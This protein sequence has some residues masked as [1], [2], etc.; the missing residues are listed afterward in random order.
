MMRV[1]FIQVMVL[2]ERFDSFHFVQGL[3]LKINFSFSKS[4]SCSVVKRGR[5]LSEIAITSYIFYIHIFKIFLIYSFGNL[6]C[7][8]HGLPFNQAR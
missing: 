4:V 5:F 1:V 7:E 8:R 3:V 6:I 2:M